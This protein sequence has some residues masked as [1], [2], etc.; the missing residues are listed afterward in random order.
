MAGR[1]ARGG[2]L[3]VINICKLLVVEGNVLDDGGLDQPADGVVVAEVV[4]AVVF[5]EA[6]AG[7][8]SVEGPSGLDWNKRIVPAV[9]H[10]RRNRQRLE[11]LLVGLELRGRPRVDGEAL[12]RPALP[13]PVDPAPRIIDRHG[14][15]DNALEPL[16]SPATSFV[17]P[18]PLLS[19]V[20]TR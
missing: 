20:M 4:A 16:A 18:E 3:F 12:P 2:P 7:D 9:H 5:T 13:A 1:A 19:N 8:Q 10:E 6:R 11:A 17:R 14:I 15:F